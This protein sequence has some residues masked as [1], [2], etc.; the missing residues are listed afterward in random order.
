[1]VLNSS[2]KDELRRQGY[3]DRDIAEIGLALDAGEFT[4]TNEKTHSRIAAETAKTM[5]GTTAFLSGIGRACFHATAIRDDESRG[6]EIFI[7]RK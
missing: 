1:M 4:F 7:R 5:L 2:Q 3:N 6:V